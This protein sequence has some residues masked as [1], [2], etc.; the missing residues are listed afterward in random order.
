MILAMFLGT[1]FV[2]RVQQLMV[3]EDT[4]RKTFEDAV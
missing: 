4:N 3:T 2:E 1:N